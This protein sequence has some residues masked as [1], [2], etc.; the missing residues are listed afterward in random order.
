ME[1]N[2]SELIAALQSEAAGL[3]LPLPIIVEKWLNTENGRIRLAVCRSRYGWHWE[4]GST[5]NER[6]PP[7]QIIYGSQGEL[8]RTKLRQFLQTRATAQTNSDSTPL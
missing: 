8:A 6:N 7:L 1:T 4:I 3:D 2:L 5:R